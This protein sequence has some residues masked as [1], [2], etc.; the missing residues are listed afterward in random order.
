[1]T[2][3]KRVGQGKRLLIWLDE[4]VIADMKRM[5][6]SQEKSRSLFVEQAIIEKL[7]RE[8]TYTEEGSNGE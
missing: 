2:L 5:A 3:Q 1:M 8:T 6:D 4:R 7:G